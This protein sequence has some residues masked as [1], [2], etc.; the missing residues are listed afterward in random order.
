MPLTTTARLGL[1]LVGVYLIIRG[2]MDFISYGV[3]LLIEQ[4][5]IW[6]SWGGIPAVFGYCRAV[7]P[8]LLMALSG[9]LMLRGW[10][11][12]LGKLV[13]GGGSACPECGYSL[14]SL[15]EPRCPECGTPVV[16]LGAT[17]TSDERVRLQRPLVRV[18][19]KLFGVVVIVVSCSNLVY[20]LLSTG[21]VLRFGSWRGSEYVIWRAGLN[22]VVLASGYLLLFRT[23]WPVM[24]VLQRDPSEKGGAVDDPVGDVSERAVWRTLARGLVCLLGICLVMCSIDAIAWTASFLRQAQRPLSPRYATRILTSLVLL[25]GAVYLIVCPNRL[26]ERALGGRRRRGAGEGRRQ[27][28]SLGSLKDVAMENSLAGGD[29]SAGHEPRTLARILLVVLGGYFL[30]TAMW[31]LCYLWPNTASLMTADR[32]FWQK[33]LGIGQLAYSC[34]GALVGFYLLFRGGWAIERLIVGAGPSRR[35]DGSNVDV[36]G[37][38]P[39]RTGQVRRHEDT[40]RG[41]LTLAGVYLFATGAAALYYAATWAVILSTDERYRYADYMSLVM[42][43]PVNLIIGGYL[44][45]GGRWLLDKLVA[46][47]RRYCLECGCEVREAGATSCPE[48]DAPLEDSGAGRFAARA[49]GERS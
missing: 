14:V 10:R 31:Y 44:V 21:P 12:L 5:T 27:C 2:G 26:A 47:D 46:A 23:G 33:H 1:K 45:F 48:C 39:G 15:T 38:D 28:H 32:Y 13:A 7:F 35:D 8:P 34:V 36:D 42:E 17:P 11:R 19:V 9:V 29:S 20:W 6:R 41:L 25:I 49:S 43:P 30:I 18:V 40:V 24:S 4:V 3:P 16:L 22:L 37:T